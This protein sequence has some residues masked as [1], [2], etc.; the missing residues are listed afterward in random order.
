MRASRLISILTSLQAHGKVTA[1]ALS[2]EFEV[3]LRTIY[4]DVDALSAA[5]IPVYSDRGSDG[6]YRLLDGY[7]TR[8]NGLSGREAEALFLMGL[9]GPAAD[10]GLGAAMAAAQL[11]LLVAMPAELRAGAERMRSRFH[12]DAPAWFAEAEQPA[13][14]TLVAGAV[15]D[16][17]RVRMSYRSWKA[18]TE[19]TAEPLGLVLEGA[20]WYLV[21]GTGDGPRTFR[22]S[23]IRAL[24]VSEDGFERPEGFSLAEY[25]T[26]GTRRLEAALYQGSATVRLSPWGVKMLAAFVPPSVRAATEVDPAPDGD[27]WRVAVMPIGSIVQA[28][29]D[30]LRFGTDAEVLA[31]FGLRDAMRAAAGRLIRLYAGASDPAT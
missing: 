20:A 9:A 8:L 1:Q 17:R 23:R 24:A 22:V 6:G 15:W 7:R 4:R 21:G 10:L 5:G 26:A 2:D 29:S 13:H 14:L 11:K 27:G 16:Q 31:P 3:S 12:L 30:M 19:R 28:C 25:W 18:E